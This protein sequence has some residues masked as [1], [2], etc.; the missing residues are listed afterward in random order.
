[1]WGFYGHRLINKLAVF[2]LPEEMID[3]YKNNLTYL[4]EH[5]VDADKRR[6]AVKGEAIRHYIDLDHWGKDA[7]DSLP[8]D[9]AIAVV[10]NGRIFLI[11][12]NEHILLFDTTTQGN[13]IIDTLNWSEQVR[14]KFFVLS[15]GLSLKDFK[16]WFKEKAWFQYDPESWLIKSKDSNI[17]LSELKTEGDILIED[18]FAVHGIIPYHLEFMYYRL[19][20]AFKNLDQE[21]ILK[22]SADMGHYIGDAHVPLHTTKNYNGQLTNQDGIHAFW[23]SRIPELFAEEQFDFIVGPAEYI[24]DIRTFSWN[25]IR[26]SHTYVDSVLFIEKSLSNSFPLDEQY[27]FETRLGVM[28]KLPCRDYAKAFHERLEYQVEDRMRESILAL[29][30]VWMSAW[31]DAGQPDLHNL[32]VNALPVPDMTDSADSNKSA[33]EARPHE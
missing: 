22:L 16:K 28:T 27:C 25:I 13:E 12:G 9:L 10:K 21:K 17:I 1:M 26:V 2:T 7:S 29:G 20:S 32:K 23:E 8:R 6:Y 15:R 5:A 18:H 19:V 33:L 14:S 24:H 30:S 4:S 31:V 11:Q 3:F